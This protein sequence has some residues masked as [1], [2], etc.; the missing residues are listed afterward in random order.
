MEVKFTGLI[1]NKIDRYSLPIIQTLLEGALR[2]QTQTL[3]HTTL[4]IVQSTKTAQ[5]WV[6][7][8]A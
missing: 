8:D 4:I 3:H 5:L 7:V 6:Q 2:S 1:I